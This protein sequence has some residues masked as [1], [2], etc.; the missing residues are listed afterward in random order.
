MQYNEQQLQEKLDQ[1]E[2]LLPTAESFP[3]W[4]AVQEL[5]PEFEQKLARFNQQQQLLSIGIMGQV[6]AG[7]STFLNALLFNGQPILPEAATPKT[8]NLTRITYG[9]KPHLVVEYYAPDEWQE[10]EKLAKS[11]ADH[12]Q[13]KVS[14]ELVNMANANGLDVQQILSQG[15]EQTFHAQNTDELLDKL[16]QFVGDNGQHTAL[17]KMTHLYLPREEL[18]GYEVVDTP[19][20]NDPVQSRTQKTRDYM[21]QCDVV[22]FLSRASQFLD[23]SDMNLLAEQLPSKG[24]KR[25]VLVAGQYDSVILDDGYDRD[26]LQATETNLKTRLGRGAAEKMQQLA[27]QREQAGNAE[28][29]KLLRSMKEPVFASTFAHGFAQWP[30]VSWGETMK[31]V[32]KELVEMAENE[33]GNYQFTHE[34]W[35]R[36]GNFPALVN[37]YESARADRIEILEQQKQGLLPEAEKQLKE[38]L[39]SLCEAVEMRH[40]QLQKGD[41]QE[42]KKQQ[43][44]CERRIQNMNATL[45]TQVDTN[46]EQARNAARD[47]LNQLQASIQSY[48]Q[49]KAR[50]GTKTE[51]E[52]YEVSTSTWY[53]PWTWGDS[54]TRYRTYSVSYEYL[55]ASDAAEQ[56]RQY[57][58]ETSLEIEQGFNRLIN[59]HKLKADLRRTLLNELDT[60]SEDFDPQQFRNLLSHTLDRLEIPELHLDAGDMTQMISQHFKGEVTS[61]SEKEELK[62]ALNE[63]LHE[64]FS[65]MSDTFRAAAKD[66]YQQLETLRDG[67]AKQL[68]E[69]VRKELKQVEADFQ[70]QAEKLASYETLIQDIKKM[71]G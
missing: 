37:H 54:E 28:A 18:R 34:D 12:S 62:D 63:A 69:D 36:I 57:A 35:Q 31:H 56:V 1:L 47:L 61:S 29:A 55:S 23:Q 41:L 70:Q 26:S 9:E 7:K 43:Q 15:S 49:L 5:K 66:L 13:A 48:S 14:K 2:Q 3:E 58:R 25:M 51:R 11:G 21:G 8:A 60:A 39:Q 22:F 71:I 68:T 24:V 10:I 6:K 32:H 44:I 59:A 40:V 30:Q 27:E 67:L 45:R 20:M 19:G 65:H 53:K 64:V 33:W 17:V 52:S 16:N 38:R 42:L 4:Q 46:L 50:T